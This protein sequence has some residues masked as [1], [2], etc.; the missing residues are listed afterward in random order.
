MIIKDEN[1]EKRLNNIFDNFLLTEAKVVREKDVI[2]EVRTKENG[3]N[4]PHCHVKRENQEASI[5]L[6]DF[7]ILSKSNNINKKQEGAFSKFVEDYKEKLREKW[8]EYHGTALL[9][10]GQ[11][12]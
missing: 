2:I 10:N 7:S 5:S 3:H 6:I 12:E 9:K 11:W 1:M 4:I 8:E